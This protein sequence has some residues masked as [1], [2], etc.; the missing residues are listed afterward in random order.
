MRDILPSRTDATPDYSNVVALLD[1][2]DERAKAVFDALSSDTS[3]HVFEHL[4]DTPATPSEL[5]TELDTSVQNVH[6]HLGKLER[7]DLI[8][9][10]ETEYS[11]RGVEVD[12]YAPTNEALVLVTGT[13][14]RRSQVKRLLTRFLGGLGLLAAASLA[15]EIWAAERRTPQPVQQTPEPGAGIGTPSMTPTA[16]IIEPQTA[17]GL[18]PGAAV[19]LG[20]L[21]MLIVA[22][23]WMY[24]DRRR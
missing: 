1:L 13:E 4:Y 19:F 20:G 24:R 6:Y 5:A 17:F 22:T 3:R 10:I 11:S 16:E 21:L 12:V 9:S 18:S 8:E 7:A 2:S 23:W 14:S 15:V